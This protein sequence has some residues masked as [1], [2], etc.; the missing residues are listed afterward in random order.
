MA[1]LHAST[2]PRERSA[3]TTEIQLVESESQFVA[4]TLVAR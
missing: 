2:Q 4:L 1:A 3:S